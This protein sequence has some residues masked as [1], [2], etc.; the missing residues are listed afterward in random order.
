MPASLSLHP[1]CGHSV[2][3]GLISDPY[4]FPATVDYIPRPQARI[5]SSLFKLFLL[6]ILLQG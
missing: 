5:K 4:A 3:S 2:I 1:A 6:D